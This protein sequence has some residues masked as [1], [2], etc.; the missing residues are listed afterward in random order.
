MGMILGQIGCAGMWMI[1]DAVTG[2]VGNYIQIGV[3]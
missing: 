3:P 2:M 1:I